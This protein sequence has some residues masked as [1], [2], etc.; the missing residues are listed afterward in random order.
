MGQSW[1][2]CNTPHTQGA[3]NTVKGGPERAE[4]QGLLHD[5]FFW[6]GQRCSQGSQQ[7][8]CLH[9]THK[10]YTNRQANMDAGKVHKPPTLD[11]VLEAVNGCQG[12][13]SASL[14]SFLF[15]E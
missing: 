15:K 12:R 13:E 8:D 5:S 11:G 9:E 14:V 10:D 7:Y 1:D 4:G 3:W 6:T 2:I